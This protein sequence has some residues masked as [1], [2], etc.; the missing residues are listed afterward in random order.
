ML[1]GSSLR[2]ARELAA[3]Y[4]CSMTEAIRI[5]VVRQRDQELGVPRGRLEER[6]QALLRLFELFDG[7][8]AASEITFARREGDG[9]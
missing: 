5:A 8:D 6:R 1:D 2:A 7:H 9:F 3:H 4:D